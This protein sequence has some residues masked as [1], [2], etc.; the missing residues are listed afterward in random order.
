MRFAVSRLVDVVMSARGRDLRRVR[1][2]QQ[3]S[4]CSVP[5]E[6]CPMGVDVARGSELDCP[7][8]NTELP[9]SRFATWVAIT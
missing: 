3:P 6:I 4:G 7:A 8:G 5:L 2:K 1:L 9:G